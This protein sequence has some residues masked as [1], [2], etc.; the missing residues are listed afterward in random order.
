MT[1]FALAISTSVRE[2]NGYVGGRFIM[3]D[4]DDDH[5]HEDED[6][7]IFAALDSALTRR[8]LFDRGTNV[9]KTL[10]NATIELLDRHVN[11]E[12]Q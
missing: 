4:V 11:N 7:C 10:T 8:L 3:R 2:D 5:G 12:D 9:R 6:V 1:I